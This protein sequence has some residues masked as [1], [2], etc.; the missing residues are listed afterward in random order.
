MFLLIWRYF[1]GNCIKD[2]HSWVLSAQTII[3]RN[4]NWV[5]LNSSLSYST[6]K[7]NSTPVD[8]PQNCNFAIQTTLW[9]LPS[10]RQTWPFWA[11]GLIHICILHC[12]YSLQPLISLIPK[13]SYEEES[14]LSSS[15]AF[16][17]VNW[18][19][20][21]NDLSNYFFLFLYT[22]SLFGTLFEFLSFL[23]FC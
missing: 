17:W 21:G 16:N 3:F 7:R 6:V 13:T 9:V 5:E 22:L 12:F 4:H 2:Q 1:H 10:I 18:N 20:F 8:F 11:K 15:R 14:T 23:F 19:N